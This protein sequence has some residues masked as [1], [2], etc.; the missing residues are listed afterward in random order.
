[1]RYI[2]LSFLKFFLVLVWCPSVF[3]QQSVYHPLTA[4]GI[5][6]SEL[7]DHG[8]YSSLGNV[9]ASFLDSAQLNYM[10][11][12]SYSSLSKGNTLFSVGVN[13]RVS[14]FQ[15]GNEQIVRT[16]GN[17]SHFAL[18]FKVKNRFGMAFGLMPYAAKGYAL[19]EKIYTGFDSLKNSYTGSGYIN[20]VFLGLSFA[21][22]HSKT[23]FLSIGA[24]AGY[25]FGGVRNQRISQLIQGSTASGGLFQEDLRLS[26]INTDIGMAF[27]QSISDRVKVNLGG[28]WAPQLRLPGTLETVFY[29]ATNLNS[30]SS[31]D[32][33]YN[34]STK[35]AILQGNRLVVSSLIELKLKDRSRKN[36]TKH[37]LLTVGLEYVKNSPHRIDFPG[38]TYDSI[39]RKTIASELYGFG[40]EFKPERYLNE[41]IATL[42]F[43]DKFSYRLGAYYGSLPYSDVQ[44]NLFKVQALTFGLGVPILSQQS[45]SSLNFSCVLGQRGTF[46]NGSINENFMSF[47]FTAVLAPAGFERWFRKRKLD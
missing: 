13:L 1:M 3:G 34:V 24:N 28:T 33:L 4:Y 11:P 40:I 14:L 42:G 39:N 7:H 19:T 37:P 22:I 6:E 18:G 12:S 17:L 5:G 30:P 15:Q 46:L 2:F 31:Y 41:N 20:R 47:Q 21:P 10:N 8:L 32:T 9:R 25:L 26:A 45:L 23:S 16:T 29:S 36:K 38:S 43:F 44:N 35:G 27:S